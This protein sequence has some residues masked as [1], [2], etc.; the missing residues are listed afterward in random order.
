MIGLGTN[1]ISVIIF[2]YNC[3]IN[4]NRGKDCCINLMSINGGYFLIPSC[5]HIRV[6]VI[7]SLGRIGR[8]RNGR[9]RS[10]EIGADNLTSICYKGNLV[11][12]YI[13]VHD[14]IINSILIK[15]IDHVYIISDMRCCSFRTVKCV[16]INVRKRSVN[17]HTFKIIATTDHLIRQ[18]CYAFSKANT[19]KSR[20]I[21]KHVISQGFNSVLENNIS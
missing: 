10:V 8:R 3:V 12:I 20:T 21:I 5:K 16:I 19:Q 14:Y 1:R 4:I 11:L 2:E 9:A 17:I 15:E 6:G 7:G 13:I 18:C